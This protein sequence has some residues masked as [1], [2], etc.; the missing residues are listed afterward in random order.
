MRLIIFPA[1]IA[2]A[3]AGALAQTGPAPNGNVSAEAQAAL[4]E[5]EGDGRIVGGVKAP[6][7]SAPWQV[8]I[9]AKGPGAYTEADIAADT[10]RAETDTKKKWLALKDKWERDHRCGG[11]LIARDWLVTAAHC[12]I[13]PDKSM[14][15]LEARGVRIGTQD[16]TSG[17]AVYRIDR[18]VIHKGY[19]PAKKINDIAL[20]HIEAEGP[21]SRSD[22]ARAQPI[23]IHGSRPDDRPLL[24]DQD[25]TVTGWGLT[26]TR[27]HSFALM[28]DGK[29]VNRKAAE[30]QQVLLSIREASV[31]A[32]EP[33]LQATMTEGTLCA[34]SPDGRDTCTGDSGGPMTRFEGSGRKR[35]PVLIGLVSWGY[36]CGIKGL[37]GVY[38]NV[39]NYRAWIDGAMRASAAGQVIA[40]ESEQPGGN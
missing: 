25:V 10:N 39:G 14:S 9:F 11:A 28:R 31:C 13:M 24:P 26:G 32:K 18:V 40:Y 8:Q 34:G 17:G 23:R 30:L 29:T 4:D 19:D 38:V 1:S 3:A 16:L 5:E 22:R 7:G 21:A 20:M 35:E 15:V 2:L 37:P 6:A 36:G 33:Q 12:A 27:E